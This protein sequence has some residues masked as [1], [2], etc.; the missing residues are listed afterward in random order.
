MFLHIDILN[1]YFFNFQFFPLKMTV[2]KTESGDN[3]AAVAAGAYNFRQ[4][5][6]PQQVRHKPN[7]C[8]RCYQRQHPGSESKSRATHCRG[9]TG[10]VLRSAIGHDAGLSLPV[11]LDLSTG[12]AC[13]MRSMIA[14]ISTRSALVNRSCDM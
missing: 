4:G 6:L 11:P 2:I 10:A 8:Y 12:G 13:K 5:A 7:D 1:L 14:C 3:E 9:S